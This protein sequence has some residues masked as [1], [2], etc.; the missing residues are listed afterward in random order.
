M[1]IHMDQSER[2]MPGVV[3]WF[4]NDLR[5]HD[6]PALHQA[7]ELAERNHAWLLP[8]YAHV[9]SPLAA[10]PWGF[11]RTGPHRTA[12]QRMALRGLSRQLEHLGSTLIEV[13]GL[14]QLVELVSALAAPVLVCEDIAAPQEQS[15]VQALQHQG[16]RVHRVWQSTLM[17]EQDLPFAPEAV[18]DR[19]TTFRQTLERHS[20]RPSAPLP[21]VQTLPSLPPSNLM[22]TCWALQGQPRSPVTLPGS[23]E[24]SSFPVGEGGFDGCEQAALKHLAQ[25]CQRGLPHTYKETRNGLQGVDYSSKWSAWLATGALSARTAWAA[26]ADF[27]RAHGA[28]ESTYWLG[29]EL[30]WRDHF[31][32]LHRKHG[33]R[34]YSARGLGSHP[35][36]SHNPELFEQW[37]RGETGQ[38]FIDAGMRELALTGYLSNRM[39][40]NV[41]SYLVHDLACDWRAGAAWFEACLL[42]YDVYSNQG[43]WLY[44]SG[45][46]TDP[47]PQRRFNPQ[48]QAS[49]YD[50][51]GR[52]RQLWA[53][54][55]LH[56]PATKKMGPL[57]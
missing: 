11:E 44:I 16:V 46:G 23:D 13:Q 18:P 49:T 40:Q 42:D 36:P 22:K 51:D 19:F 37:R 15:Q 28:N 34:L 54:P 48:L 3:F 55:W 41:A 32:W 24:R 33:K 53:R 14:Q 39:R 9:D 45:R 30:L 52:Y 12:W 1:P 20:V 29:F 7:I 10:T 35:V 17:A 50:P 6:Q 27:E 38:P 21:A 2:Q 5:L 25:Y 26:V 47:H 4:R 43:N 56:S 57:P 8:V 31:R